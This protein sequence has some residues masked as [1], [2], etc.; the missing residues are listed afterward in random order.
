MWRADIWPREIE[1]SQR[2]QLQARVYYRLRYWVGAAQ[3]VICQLLGSLRN[4]DNNGNKNVTNL[5]I[6]HWKTIDLHALHV[7]FS[8]LDILQTFSFFLRRGF[9]CFAV[10]RTTWAHDNKFS[11]LS[12]LWA[13]VPFNSWIVRTHF[14]TVMTLD[15]SEMIAETRSY[16]FRWRSRCRR[17]RLCVN[18]LLFVTFF[19]T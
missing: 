1:D 5:H 13:L 12:Y 10:V 6:W 8:F 19:T 14:A 4:H 3:C 7:H 11:I 2:S 18:C 16:I 17:L 9:T 15:N